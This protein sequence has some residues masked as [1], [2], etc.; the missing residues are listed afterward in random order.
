[1][2]EAIISGVILWPCAFLMLGIGIHQLKS[3]KPVGFYSGEEPPKAEEISDVSAWNKYHGGM[4]VIYGVLIA[5]AWILGLLLGDDR[6]V[7]PII[8]LPGLPPFLMI[9]IHKYLVKRYMIR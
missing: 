1:M 3:T 4:W 5:L 9:C 6:I 7:I 8:L 2:G